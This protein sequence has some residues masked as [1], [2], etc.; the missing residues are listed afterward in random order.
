M[1][2]SWSWKIPSLLQC[3]PS[4]YQLLLIYFVPESPRWLVNKGRLDD[5]R[6]ILNRYH[7]GEDTAADVWPLVRYEMAEIEA[8]I[9]A[10]KM[11]NTRSYLDFWA[12]SKH[13]PDFP[14]VSRSPAQPIMLRFAFRGKQMAS[15]HCHH[16]RPLRAVGR[17]WPRLFLPSPRP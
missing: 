13:T 7:A 14:M 11:Q 6:R 8:A 12:T 15:R 3:V 9:E 1:D 10:E 16:S 4:I 17:Q 2:N 5:A